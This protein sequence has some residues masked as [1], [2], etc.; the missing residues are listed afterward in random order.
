[1]K[2]EFDTLGLIRIFAE[3]ETENA[4]IRSIDPEKVLVE[5]GESYQNN[6]RTAFLAL[7]IDRAC[8][9]DRKE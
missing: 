8:V 3:S 5:R 7:E 1:M 9:S 4:V 2:T 6:K